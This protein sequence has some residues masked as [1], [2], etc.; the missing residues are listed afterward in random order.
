MIDLTPIYAAGTNDL[1][2]LKNSL[3]IGY[4]YNTQ[5]VADEIVSNRHQNELTPPKAVTRSH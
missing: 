2:Q 5:L 3:K 1:D 4:Y